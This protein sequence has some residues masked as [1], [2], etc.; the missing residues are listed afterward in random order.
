M[1]Q[2]QTFTITL[3]E[4]QYRMLLDLQERVI[5]VKPYSDSEWLD[6]PTAKRT[7]ANNE[8]FVKAFD[9]VTKLRG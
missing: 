2:Q 9:F 7:A 8:F 6:V 3:D 4:A 5:D 1:T